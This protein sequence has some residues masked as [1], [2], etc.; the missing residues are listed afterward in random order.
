MRP[1]KIKA[2]EKVSRKRIVMAEETKSQSIR[3]KKDHLFAILCAVLFV[4]GVFIGYQL[5]KPHAEQSIFA[6]YAEDLKLDANKFNTCLES[7]KYQG[8]IDSDYSTAAAIGLTGT[9]AFIINGQLI[10][11][12]YPYE[13]FKQ[14]FEKELINSS[15]RS[16]ALTLINAQDQTLGS[17][18][19]PIVMIEFSDYQCPYCAKFENETMGKIREEYVGTGK[20]F[21]VYKNLPLRQIHPLSDTAS[22]AA[23][24][25]AEQG[26]FWE[27]HAVLYGKQAEW[28]E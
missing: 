6:K 17:A 14:A 27:Y 26:K 23:L 3:I 7:A 8:Q 5:G 2:K 18:N 11:G 4:A 9:P 19:A 24:C 15:N 28:S 13:N 21:F 25:A 12:A 1:H 10:S 22:N 16:L 20:I